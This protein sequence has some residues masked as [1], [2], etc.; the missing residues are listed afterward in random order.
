MSVSSTRVRTCTVVRS[1]IFIS[2]VPPLTFC[3]VD[4]ITVP[5]STVFSMIVPVIGARTSVS[6]SVMRAFSTATFVLTTCDS[7]FANSSWV[8]STSV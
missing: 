2:V 4:A 7:A 8:C 6:S 3:V 1:A 5:G